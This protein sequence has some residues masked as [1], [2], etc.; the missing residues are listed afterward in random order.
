MGTATPARAM[1][2]TVVGTPDRLSEPLNSA[3]LTD[4]NVTVAINAALKRLS[5]RK[6]VPVIR[7]ESDGRIMLPVAI[8]SFHCGKELLAL[9][10]AAG[11]VEKRAYSMCGSAENRLR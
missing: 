8:C 11:V 5:L 9:H 2:P 10:A 3:A 1:S 4:S 7:C 6:I